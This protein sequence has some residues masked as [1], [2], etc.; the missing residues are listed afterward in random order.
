MA[1]KNKDKNYK[2]VKCSGCGRYEKE[3]DSKVVSWFCS[4]CSVGNWNFIRAKSGKDLIKPKVVKKNTR[5]NTIFGK[6]GIIK[7][8]G[9]KYKKTTFY[10]IDYGTKT[11]QIEFIGD[12]QIL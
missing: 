3:V 5:V 7:G 12:F 4:D 1:K 11:Q 10:I 9:Y 2:V 8:V 6:S